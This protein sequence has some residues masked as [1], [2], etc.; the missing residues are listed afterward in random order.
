ML[1]NMV[2]KV[3]LSES[4][5]VQVVKHITFHPYIPPVLQI[6]LLECV[7]LDPVA[8]AQRYGRSLEG[9]G[10]KLYLFIFPSEK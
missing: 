3:N 5:V 4:Q 2:G 7:S 8:S 6:Q 1:P 10:F 9:G